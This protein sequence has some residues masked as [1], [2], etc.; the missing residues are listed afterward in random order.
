M[1][2]LNKIVFINSAGTSI[3][4][5]EVNLDGNVHFIGTQGVGKSTLLRAVL[6]FYNADTRKLGIRDG[7][8]NYTEFYYPYFNSYIVYEVKTDTGYFCV[9]SFK[10][11]NQVAFRFIASEYKKENYIAD[12]KAFD[13]WDKIRDSLGK[14]VVYSPIISRFSEYRDII[15]GN[16]QDRKF[17]NYYLLESKQYQ[18]VP[19]TISN[20]FL[21]TKL[22]ASIIKQTIISSLEES[23]DRIELARYTNHLTGFEKQLA[24]IKRWTEKDQRGNSIVEKLAQKI[25]EEYNRLIFIDKEKQQLASKL[26]FAYNR[27]QNEKPEI[28]N[29]LKQSNDEIKDFEIEINKLSL[30]YESLKTALNQEIGKISGEIEKANKKQKEY[31]LKDI[32]NVILR[33]DNEENV[34]SQKQLLEKEKSLLTDKFRDIESRFKDIIKQYENDYNQLKNNKEAEK[35]AVKETYFNDCDRIKKQSEEIIN[36]INTQSKDKLSFFDNQIIEKQSEITQKNIEFQVC[37]KTDLYKNELENLKSELDELRLIIT[38]NESELE[39]VKKEKFSLTKNFEKEKELKS[40]SF[41]FDLDKLRSQKDSLKTKSDAINNKLENFKDSLYEWLN[42]EVAG[43][44]NTIGQVVNDDVLF[45]KNL[46]PK[47]VSTDNNALYG[48]EIDLAEINKSVKTIDDY[49]T[50]KQQIEDEISTITKQI[51]DTQKQKDDELQ[52]LQTLCNNELK[53]LKDRQQKAE[54]TIKQSQPKFENKEIDYKNLQQKAVN[55]KAQ[56]L[57][58]FKEEL[59]KLNSEKQGIENEKKAFEKQINDKIKVQ[60]STLK[61]QLDDRKISYNETIKTI[62]S[63]IIS[64]NKSLEN[65]IAETNILREKELKNKGADT[66]KISNLEK[67][68]KQCESELLFIKQNRKLVSDYQKDKEELFDRLNEFEANLYNLKAKLELQTQQF[69]TEK[70][71]LKIQ[72]DNE[73]KK[74]S[75][76]QLKLNDIKSEIEKFE[77]FAVSEE[78]T[79]LQA[80]IENYS[81]IDSSEEKC[82]KLIDEINLKSN[83]YFKE[84]E[85]MRSDI[86]KFMGNF[87]EKNLFSFKTKCSTKEDY[88]QF[89]DNLDEFIRE[90]KFAE[91]QKRFQDRFANIVNVIG[92]EIQQLI[93]K[94]G[95]IESIKNAINKDFESRNFVGAINSLQLDIAP[96]E[97]KIYQTLVEI[98]KFQT[99]NLNSF[100]LGNNLFSQEID[101]NTKNAQ[102]VKLLIYLSKEIAASKAEYITLSDSF[103][104]KFRIVENNQDSG[105][106]QKLSNVGSEGTDILI[107]AMIN[108]LL[109]NVFKERSIKKT[110]S[111][112]KLHC[113]MDEIGK[114]HSTNIK[115]ILNFANE[116]NIILINSS[117]NPTN[118]LDYKY[119]YILRR[120]NDNKTSVT[121]LISK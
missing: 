13:S 117:P 19:L 46:N 103:E 24:D 59:S 10:Y 83:T 18:K 25:G 52:K 48:V 11:Q 93:N 94:I 104:L 14:N 78:F 114:L 8:K 121:R 36:G 47:L 119:T 22:D 66:D 81:P 106:V 73:H 29:L 84:Y 95:E 98:K 77:E 39:L 105:W 23:N 112:F 45:N 1:R 12:S 87:D 56:K 91:Y 58:G 99:N 7:Q 5:A 72:L 120:S 74:H 54:Y 40:K 26:G 16:F 110:K 102:A 3:P 68:I 113:M 53:K 97:N 50:E 6:F 51:Q 9:L 76:L 75:E 89:A 20:V 69:D 82:T 30:N 79:M 85:Q 2:Y 27:T 88:F 90:N 32:K 35:I 86:N 115:G 42:K 65:K 111:E 21:N 17:R 80:Y 107:K 38:E 71:K 96:S 41:D 49:N 34:L 67:Q 4:Y 44:E 15:Y 33:V 55:D 70:S 57:A 28:E 116:R 61:K 37:Q 62:D 63:E 118:V 100:G 101:T 31:A 109:L 108:I 92:S 43:W 64:A 60:Q